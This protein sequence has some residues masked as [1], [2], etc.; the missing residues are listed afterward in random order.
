M[1]GLLSYQLFGC[2]LFCGF[3]GVFRIR[4]VR[5]HLLVLDCSDKLFARNL[6]LTWA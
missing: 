4:G 2:F 6:Q 5:Q 3:G 1:L